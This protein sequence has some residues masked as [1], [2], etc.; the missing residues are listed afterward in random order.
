MV[1]GGEVLCHSMS[2][3]PSMLELRCHVFQVTIVRELRVRLV[4]EGC[5]S[6]AWVGAGVVG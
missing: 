5:G 4:G 2:M 1:L 6:E 3:M